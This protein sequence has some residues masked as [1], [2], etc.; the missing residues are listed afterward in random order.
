MSGE[1][2]SGTRC[3]PFEWFNLLGA[4]EPTMLCLDYMP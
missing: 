2:P 1:A 3:W 4:V